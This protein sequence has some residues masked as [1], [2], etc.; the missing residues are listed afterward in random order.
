MKPCLA[1][2]SVIALALSAAAVPAETQSPPAVTGTDSA[3][4]PPPQAAPN[5][6]ANSTTPSTNAAPMEGANSFTEAQAHKRITEAGFSEVTDLSK[7]DKGIWRGKA[8]KAGAKV[9]VALDFKGNV[10]QSN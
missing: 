8:I 2:L 7:D 6:P 10:V 1:A 4:T 9:S 3:N 5:A